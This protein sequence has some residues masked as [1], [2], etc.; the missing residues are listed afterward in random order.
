M[1]LAGTLL[2]HHRLPGLKTMVW[3]SLGLALLAGFGWF[4]LQTADFANA[5]NFGDIAAAIPIVA[6]DTRFGTL[7]I[8]RCAALILAS[9]LFQAGWA[10]P[11]ALVAGAAIVAESWLSHGGAMGGLTGTVLLVTSIAHLTAAAI[12]LGALPALRFA[13][14]TLP[15][16]AAGP[17]ARNFSPIGMA[18]VALITAT[19]VIQYFFLI[20]W[21]ADL[22]NTGYGLVASFKIIALASLVTLAAINRT[23][24]TPRL[25]ASRAQLLRSINAEIVIGLVTLLAAGLILQLEPPAM[26][27]MA[28]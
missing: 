27:M 1:F 13:I 7:L 21:P 10:R 22:I 25:P 26:A 24:F 20:G 14:K 6:Q 18:C 19:A 15:A 4:L 2:R 16:D 12:W 11:A 5:R 23:R 8:G 17:L 9:L 3:M 28:H